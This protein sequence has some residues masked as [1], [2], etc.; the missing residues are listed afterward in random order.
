[1]T[2]Y[3]SPRSSEMSEDQRRLRDTI[4]DGPRGQAGA[5]LLDAD[6]RLVGPFGPMLLDP[7]LGDH[8]QAIGLGVQANQDLPPEIRELI[9]LRVASA[10]DCPFEWN[11]HLARARTLG[12]A[13]EMLAAMADG[14]LP[15]DPDPTAAALLAYAQALLDHAEIDGDLYDRVTEVAGPGAVFAVTVIVGYYELLANLFRG[16][17]LD[18]PAARP[19]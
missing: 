18:R 13:D 4:V 7:A 3:T 10:R 6:G 5:T 12:V 19:V 9:I 14:H 16:F 2:R 11:A 1:M 8:L 15:P 17:A